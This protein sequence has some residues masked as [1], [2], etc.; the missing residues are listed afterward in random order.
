M[1][2]SKRIDDMGFIFSNF[3]FPEFCQNENDFSIKKKINITLE[4]IS[5]VYK[6]DLPIP[7][8]WGR[9]KPEAY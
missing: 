9:E 6:G 3:Y 7:L 2:T 8:L 4:T 1:T 5:K